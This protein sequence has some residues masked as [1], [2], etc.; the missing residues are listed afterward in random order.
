GQPEPF[1]VEVSQIVRTYMEQQFNLH[2]PE[3]T[4]E[5]FLA[6]LQD[7]SLLSLDQKRSLADFLMRCD[8]VKFARYEPGE[9]ELRDLYDAAVRLIEETQWVSPVQAQQFPGGQQEP[10]VQPE[11]DGTQK[12]IVT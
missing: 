8:L 3:R 9:P 7:S 4:T 1:C 2:A 5:E 10:V 12:S 6:E 11:P